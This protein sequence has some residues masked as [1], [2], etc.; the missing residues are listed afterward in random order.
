[1]A[2]Q[3]LHFSKLRRRR[4]RKLIAREGFEEDVSEQRS[5]SK[6]RFKKRRFG[7]RRFKKK[8]FNQGAQALEPDAFRLLTDTLGVGVQS[9]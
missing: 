9:H 7:K 5:V 8:P 1:M 4:R 6:D 3:R 2:Q